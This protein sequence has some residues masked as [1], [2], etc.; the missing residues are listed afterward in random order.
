LADLATRAASVAVSRAISR[1]SSVNFLIKLKPI[2]Q[3]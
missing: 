1:N 3:A 2:N